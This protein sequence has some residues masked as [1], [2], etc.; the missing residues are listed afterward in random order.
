[1][2]TFTPDSGYRL[3]T[4]IVFESENQLRLDVYTPDSAHN[5]P[6]VIFFFGEGDRWT[7]GIK[8]DYQF[9]GQALAA[10]GFVVVIPNYRLYPT[11]RFPAFLYDNANAVLWAHEHIAA[12][13]GDP[14]KLVVM[15][16][17]AGA[18]NAA[19]L[20]L[21][22]EILHHV[23]GDRSWLR[24]MIGLAGPYDFLPIVDPDLRDLFGPPERFEQ[25]QPTNYVD[26]RNPPMLLMS[27]IDDQVISVQNTRTLADR[28]AKA[29][30]SAETVL[31]PKMSHRWILLVLSSTLGGK[32]DV[33]DHISQFVTQCTT[34]PPKAPSGGPQ[35]IA[36]PVPEDNS[37]PQA[38][39][40]PAP[41]STSNAPVY[42]SPAPVP[43]G[44]TSLPEPSGPPPVNDSP[45]APPGS[46]R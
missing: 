7:Q 37:R 45:P 33:V 6:V 26:G 1:L 12:Y 30:G 27:G 3:A 20:A 21:D 11:V 35:G 17:G 24:G 14:G 34:G 44:N 32:A 19:M 23:G 8:E 10:R 18:Y 2:N 39:P 41:A 5:A 28:V 42:M 31:Y 46:P 38:L 36:A 16:H 29:G 13:G 9:V 15:G 22:P 25:T 40:A 43:P 4:N